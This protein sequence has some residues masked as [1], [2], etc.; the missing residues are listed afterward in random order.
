MIFLSPIFPQLTRFCFSFQNE[1]EKR[2][3]QRREQKEE[4]IKHLSEIYFIHNSIRFHLQ[5]TEIPRIPARLHNALHIVRHLAVPRARHDWFALEDNRVSRLTFPHPD[6]H[7]SIHHSRVATMASHAESNQR[8]GGGVRVAARPFERRDNRAGKFGEKTRDGAKGG[9]CKQHSERL[10]REI[11]SQHEAAGVLQAAGHHLVLLL[12]HA[13]QRC[14]LGCLLHGQPD[15]ERHRTRQ[16]VSVH[17]A[18]RHRASLKLV[19]R[20]HSTQIVLSA[21]VGA[22]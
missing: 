19:Y 18:H 22:R 16:R 8:R 2:R 6:L 4:G 17:A 12:C 20:M 3:R 14:Q 11:E 10:V 21:N 15:E 13:V 5:R 7:D 9:G 1:K